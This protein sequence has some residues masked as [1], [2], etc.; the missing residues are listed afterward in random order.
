MLFSDVL[1]RPVC[2]SLVYGGRLR[3]EVKAVPPRPDDPGFFQFS[4]SAKDWSERL[5]QWDVQQLLPECRPHV[6]KLARAGIGPLCR[7]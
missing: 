4:G 3:Q 1:L 2:Y 6:G 5:C 7:V